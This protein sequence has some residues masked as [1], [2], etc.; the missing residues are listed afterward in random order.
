MH[1][2]QLPLAPVEIPKALRF[3]ILFVCIVC[4]RVCMYMCVYVVLHVCVCMHVE[5]RRQPWILLLR[6]CPPYIRSQGVSLSWDLS[7]SFNGPAR[8][9]C[10]SHFSV[11]GLQGHPAMPGVVI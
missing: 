10:V 6:R 2:G 4:V 9:L 11:L 5:D 8:D 1:L 7:S 3:G